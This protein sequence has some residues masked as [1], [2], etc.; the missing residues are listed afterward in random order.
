[1]SVVAALEASHIKRWTDSN[2]DERLDPN[3]G[4]LLTANLH[5]LF[6]AGLIS[7][8]D[9]GKMI[10]SSKLSKS[11]Q[12]LLGINNKKTFQETVF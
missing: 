2:N 4:I 8:D 9:L 7:F 1:L 3:N 6:D 11:E 10:I 12:T 5:R